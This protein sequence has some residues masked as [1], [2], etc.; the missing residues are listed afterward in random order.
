MKFEWTIS[1]GTVIQIVIL[2]G[3]I[4]LAYSTIDKR[5]A[6]IEQKIQLQLEPILEWWNETKT[7]RRVTSGRHDD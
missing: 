5:I 6:L 3:T 4:V 7:R 1:L 2:V